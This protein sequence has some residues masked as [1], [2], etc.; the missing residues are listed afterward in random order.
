MSSHHRAAPVTGGLQSVVVFSCDCL[1]EESV[2][3]FTLLERLAHLC[4]LLGIER[5]QYLVGSFEVLATGSSLGSNRLAEALELVLGL[6]D[7]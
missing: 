6:R 7:E 3:R 4:S 2:L 5:F 1:C